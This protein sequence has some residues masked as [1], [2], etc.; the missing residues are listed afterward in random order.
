MHCWN[1]KE[2]FSIRAQLL[3]AL[4]PH[5]PEDPRKNKEDLC[6]LCIPSS[7]V[8]AYL[9]HEPLRDFGLGRRLRDISETIPA[10]EM[11]VFTVVVVLIAAYYRVGV[12]SRV[13]DPCLYSSP[14]HISGGGPGRLVR[15]PLALVGSKRRFAIEVVVRGSCCSA[16]LDEAG[17]GRM[18]CIVCDGP[19]PSGYCWYS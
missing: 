18:E 8:Y 12:Y 11:T 14:N 13:P 7:V 15:L 19:C 9:S 10:L 6:E 17:L 2:F 16:G 5:A 1:T 3:P 4:H